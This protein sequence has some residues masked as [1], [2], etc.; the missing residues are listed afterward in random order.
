MKF[1]Y[2]NDSDLEVCLVGPQNAIDF[3]ILDP[4]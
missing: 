2:D 4:R 3:A 1:Y